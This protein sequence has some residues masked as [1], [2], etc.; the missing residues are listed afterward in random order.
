[1]KTKL[2]EKAQLIVK[3]EEELERLKRLFNMGYELEVRWIP[4]PYSKLS[5]EVK[6]GKLIV[7][8]ED[9]EDALVTLRHEFIDYVLSRLV[10]PYRDVANALIKLV[11]N[12]AYREKEN[13]VNA[14][15]KVLDQTK[16]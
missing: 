1:L 10:S 15:L 9:P 8:E 3:L 16:R 7:Y 2:D 4:N 13:I 6:D 14:L 5:G 11:T 12:R